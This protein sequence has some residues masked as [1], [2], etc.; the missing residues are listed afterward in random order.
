MSF[1]RVANCYQWMEKIV[2]RTDLEKVRNFHLRLVRDAE[3]ILIL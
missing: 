2:F 3:S 1:D